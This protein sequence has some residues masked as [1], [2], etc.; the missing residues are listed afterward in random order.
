[1]KDY[2]LIRYV[3]K[4]TGAKPKRDK[5]SLFCYFPFNETCIIPVLYTF[6]KGKSEYAFFDLSD[7]YEK[8]GKQKYS[9]FEKFVNVFVD[10]N[11]FYKAD[12]V[13]GNL[14]V[15]SDLNVNRIQHET[16]QAL[17]NVSVIIGVLGEMLG[18]NVKTYS[19]ENWRNLY[20][21]F[22]ANQKRNSLIGG[23]CSLGVLAVGITD[24]VLLNNNGGAEGFI[25]LIAFLLL[26]AI[27]AGI[28]GIIY[29]CLKHRHYKRR[30]I[31]SI[32]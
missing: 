8:Y 26:L 3:A 21:N 32:K 15:I 23:I 14:Y 2:K 4:L 30:L 31:K 5:G 16:S 10:K 17:T 22:L 29:F 1:M 28:V 7:V 12:K 27:P 9:S 19:E 11:N 20:R 13:S 18:L 6:N 25:A 24:F